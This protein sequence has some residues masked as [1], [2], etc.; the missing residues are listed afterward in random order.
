MLDVNSHYD[1]S[2]QIAAQKKNVALHKS[3]SSEGGKCGDCSN[4]NCGEKEGKEAGVS[5][6]TKQDP[7]EPDP[8]S[9]SKVIVET[10]KAKAKEHNKVNRIKVTVAQ[11][12]KAYESGAKAYDEKAL[13]GSTRG[14]WALARVNIFIKS[15]SKWQSSD[16][17]KSTR[18]V[19][20]TSDLELFD[21]NCTEEEINAAT[22]EAEGRGINCDF[23]PNDLYI[24][25]E[26][27]GYPYSKFI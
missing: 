14:T 3:L 22:A 18:E 21:F 17:K 23:D 19:K 25:A 13:P 4:C 24:S 6:D 7:A 8:V 12:K 27:D 11:L 20:N 16:F 10:L 2:E 15:I 1:F 5:P 9:L 26:R